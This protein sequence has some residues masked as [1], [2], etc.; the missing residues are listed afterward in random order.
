MIFPIN[1]CAKVEDDA[2]IA[3]TLTHLLYLHLYSQANE[4]IKVS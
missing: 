2:V 1:N 3:D 4:L